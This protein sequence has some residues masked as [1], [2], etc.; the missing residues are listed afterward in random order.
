MSISRIRRPLGPDA[1]AFSPSCSPASFVFA[2]LS[3]APKIMWPIQD[4]ARPPA[5]PAN[6]GFRW[7]HEGCAAG[8]GPAAADGPLA[9]EGGGLV[10]CLAV[11]DCSIG[12]APLS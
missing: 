9:T 11:V 2:L 12:F 8:A 6:R 10:A 4:P 3:L 1:P 7:I 5:I